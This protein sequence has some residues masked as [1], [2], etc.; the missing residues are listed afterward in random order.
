MTNKYKTYRFFVTFGQRSPFRNGYVEI[1]V[2]HQTDDAVGET[3]ARRAAHALA[4]HA[5]G[6]KWSNIY[7]H[8]EF[9]K[10]KNESDAGVGV[11]DLFPLGKL[12][13]TLETYG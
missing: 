5:M 7:G 13:E 10:S 9:V 2:K 4:M 11:E 12:G 8:D 1:D 6:E 3:A